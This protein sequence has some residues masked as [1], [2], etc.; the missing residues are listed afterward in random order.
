VA[1]EAAS[2]LGK[3]SYRVRSERLGSERIREIARANG[4]KGGQPPRCSDAGGWPTNRDSYGPTV[5]LVHALFGLE[6]RT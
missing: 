3:R 4:K 5:R 6:G 2:L 1:S